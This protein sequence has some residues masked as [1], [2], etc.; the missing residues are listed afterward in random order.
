MHTGF[1]CKVCVLWDPYTVNQPVPLRKHFQIRGE[2][3]TGGPAYSQ[4]EKGNNR[5]SAYD[6]ISY[7]ISKS[8]S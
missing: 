1:M 8:M 6:I 3:H 7:L 4:E 2:G 5:F